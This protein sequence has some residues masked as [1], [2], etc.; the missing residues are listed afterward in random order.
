MKYYI[1]YTLLVLIQ[2][3]TV[4][5]AQTAD[6][7]TISRIIERNNKSLLNAVQ[8][9]NKPVTDTTAKSGNTIT[10]P[11]TTTG[12]KAVQ[13]II[14]FLPVAFFSVL[15]SMI[16]FKLRKDG[17]K[18]SEILIDKEAVAERKKAAA[19]TAAKTLETKADVIK[20]N[21]QAFT[22]P[23]QVTA[24]TD[25]LNQPVT[26]TETETQKS[27]STSRLIVFICGITSIALACC[28]CT[29]YFYKSFTGTEKVDLGNLT[30]VLYG[31]GLGV[32][33]YGFNKIAAALK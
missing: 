5:T 3:S 1:F 31:L 32:L 27:Q 4:C 12:S 2:P 29:F 11:A 19:T 18:L 13:D 24:A 26:D 25:A 23:D 20:S 30:N 33:P 16:F 9:Q 22:S 7:A 14:T 28:I 21:P 17:V 15:V 6:S 10:K 8:A